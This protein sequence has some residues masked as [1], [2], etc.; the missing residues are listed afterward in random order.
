KLAGRSSGTSE[1]LT[2]QKALLVLRKSSDESSYEILKSML[3]SN[4]ISLS[5]LC[6]ILDLT[7]YRYVYSRG[8]RPTKASGAYRALMRT[9]DFSSL[10]KYAWILKHQEV[11]AVFQLVR[12]KRT[13]LSALSQIFE[14]DRTLLEAK[15]RSSSSTNL[16]W[17]FVILRSSLLDD[18]WMESR[19][20]SAFGATYLDKLW[21]PNRVLRRAALYA[22][23]MAP[24]P[25]LTFLT[26]D[27]DV[28][29]DARG[30]PPWR[31]PDAWTTSEEKYF[32]KFKPRSKKP[33]GPSI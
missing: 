18:P 30:N 10:G 11:N 21:P 9:Y 12:V 17:A 32:I 19:A 29:E 13:I 28:P 23:F 27:F 25:V 15:L 2:W 24:E 4:E 5:E 20:K 6:E 26:H 14:N 3:A 22:V 31:I 1:T 8:H 7:S 33:M 16:F